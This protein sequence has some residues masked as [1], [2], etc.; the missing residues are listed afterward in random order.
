MAIPYLPL[1]ISAAVLGGILLFAPRSEA[2]EGPGI[3]PGPGPNG[4]GGGGGGT[5]PVDPSRFPPGSAVGIVVVRA[6]D[7]G[8]QGRQPGVRIN[9]QPKSRAAGASQ[10][11]PGSTGDEIPSGERVLVL[12]GPIKDAENRT[13]RQ[14]RT[15]KGITGYAAFIDP[16]G[17]TVNIEKAPESAPWPGGDNDVAVAGLPGAY[18][19]V[20]ACGVPNS[21]GCPPGGP[22][23]YGWAPWASAWG[24]GYGAIRTDIVGQAAPALTP[25]GSAVC[26]RECLL[27]RPFE[28]G[29]GWTVASKLPVGTRVTVAPPLPGNVTLRGPGAEYVLVQTAAGWGWIHR[30][31]LQGAAV[32]TLGRRRYPPRLRPV[33]A[34]PFRPGL[35][36]VA[37]NLP[38]QGSPVGPFRP[39]MGTGVAF[40]LPP[41]V[42]R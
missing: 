16:N 39:G 10:A 33:P 38:A 37:A 4:G 3:G 17:T 13:W 36:P 24:P 8:L 32:A 35:P 21:V 26:V 1:G 25:G 31:Q 23:A 30:S 19:R 5:I 12:G 11:A 22:A 34:G 2:A 14:V 41:P 20:G 15:T 6:D 28:R 40:P 42:L 29:V 27:Y 7:P 9:N 18:A